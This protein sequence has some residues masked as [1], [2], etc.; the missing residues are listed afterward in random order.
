M[1]IHQYEQL[2][3]QATRDQQRLQEQIKVFQGRVA[4]SPAIEEQYKQ[5]TR[6][7]DTAQKFY[8]DRLA[9]R[10][11]SEMQTAMEREQQGEQMSILNAASLPD[12]P[13]FPNRPLFAAGGLALGLGLGLGLALWL[14]M[15]DTSLRTETDVQAALDLPVLSQVPWVGVDAAEKN[16]NR[17]RKPGSPARPGQEDKETVE[18]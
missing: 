3:G 12:D 9:N 17:K 14:E 10:K 18:V 8:E 5:L 11:Q 13:S 2:I 15:R 6:D 4:L 1:Q 7:Y 16:G